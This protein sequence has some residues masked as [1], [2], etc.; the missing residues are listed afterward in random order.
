VSGK[1]DWYKSIRRLIE[2]PELRKDLGSQLKEDVLNLRNE[3]KW[4]EV[5]TQIYESFISKR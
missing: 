1:K 5:R 3:A 2:N 4:R